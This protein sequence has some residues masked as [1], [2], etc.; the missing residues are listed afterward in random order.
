MTE[1]A[2]GFVHSFEPLGAF[3]GPGL[4]CVVFLAGCP[5]RCR[6]CHNPDMLESGAGKLMSVKEVADRVCRDRAYIEGVTLSGGEPMLQREFTLELLKT[7]KRR[8]L[9]TALDTA[10]SVYDERILDLSSLVI[11]DIKHTDKGEF[12]RL[13]GYDADN[14]FKTLEYLKKSGKPFWIRQVI[15]PGITDGEKNIRALARM[16]EGAQKAELLPYHTM[17]VDKWEK[18]G[19]SY[20]LYGVSP[21]SK[22][23]M[24]RAEGV[25]CDELKRMK[26]SK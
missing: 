20:S 1:E 22:E 18:L 10:G 16:S 13:C 24:A 3:D 7:F 4:R 21:P 6:Y 15:V 23:D 2:K 14:T 19:L 25:L 8:R 9:H 5:M 17:G 11:L 12:A 26:E